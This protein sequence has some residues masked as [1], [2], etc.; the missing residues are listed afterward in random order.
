MPGSFAAPFVSSSPWNT[1]I[2]QLQ[3]VYSDPESIQNIQFQDSHLA[4]TGA[5]FDQVVYDTPANS[6]VVTW[7]YSVLNL[8]TV[9]D[10]Y[11]VDGTVNLHTPID[12][13]FANGSDA[14]AIFGDPDGVHYW[15]LWGGSYDP[16]ML[17]YHA[18]YLVEGD[19]VS[20]TGWGQNG[21]GAGIRAAG[22]SLLGGLVTQD[23]LNSLSIPHALSIELAPEQLK[24][25]ATQSDQFVFPAVSA[26]SD[27]LTSYAGTIPMGAH[28][29][30]PPSLELSHAGL[31][32]E[33]LALAEA[34]QT[35]GGYVVDAA[36][37]TTSLAQVE[38]G[39]PQQADHL[40]TDINWIR[41]HLVM[42]ADLI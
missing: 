23:E 36:G 28:F 7:T 2:D 3:P 42:T 29:A 16:L 34:Y 41:D 6:P 40:F 15:E 17:T 12:H 35:Y 26:D 9:G 37:F 11:H 39:T 4:N 24:A 5:K 30:L 19:Y 8:T 10:T 25:G 32:P 31:T 33:G 38:G 27:S 14:W 21:D 1:P 13:K 20:G 18:D 22:A